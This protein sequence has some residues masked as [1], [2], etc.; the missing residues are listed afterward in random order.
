VGAGDTC[1]NAVGGYMVDNK[2][3]IK[4]AERLRQQIKESGHNTAFA[5]GQIDQI[6]RNIR[7]RKKEKK[8]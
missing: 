5:L 8:V 3:L 7:A 1:G 2:E 4:L 6:E